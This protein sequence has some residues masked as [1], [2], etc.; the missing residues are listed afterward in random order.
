MEA[1]AN[2]LNVDGVEALARSWARSLRAENKSEKTVETYLE[3]TTQLGRFLTASGMPLAV[4]SIKREHVES[5][6]A[7]L[8][9]RR[10]ANTASN[11]FRALA[12]FFKWLEEEGE[13]RQSPM[14]RMRPPAVPEVPVPVLSDA[15]LAKLLKACDGKAFDDRRDEA[16]LRLLIDCGLRLSEVTNLKLEDLDLDDHRVVHVL[17]KGRRPRAVP[18]GARTAKAID[19]YLRMR[20]RHA[21]ADGAA[22]WLGRKGALGTSG[23]MQMVRRRGAEAGIENMHAH[24]LRHTFAHGWLAAEGGEGDLMRIAGWRSRAMVNR[25]AASTADERAHAAHRRL[26]LGD[27]V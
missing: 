5:F 1:V 20:Q 9:T 12:C 19:R 14:T 18:F 3:A 17:G 27:R 11:R 24:V 4:G 22:L 15:D 10:S 25:Y 21:H 2:R 8:L 13:I 26:R 6:I 23:V 7:D 16:I